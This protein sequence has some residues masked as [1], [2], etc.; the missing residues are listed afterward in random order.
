VAQLLQVHDSTLFEVH[1]NILDEV[2]GQLPDVLYQELVT[3]SG[4]TVPFPF[5]LDVGTRWK[6]SEPSIE[7]LDEFIVGTTA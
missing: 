2:V 3:A 4:R 5:S 1:E 6:D 7:K